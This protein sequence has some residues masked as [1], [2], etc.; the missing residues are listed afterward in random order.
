MRFS[1]YTTICE[2]R[3]A[4]MRFS[5]G[6]NNSGEDFDSS[7]GYI[8]NISLFVLVLLRDKVRKGVVDTSSFLFSA[9]SVHDVEHEHFPHSE[10]KLQKHGEFANDGLVNESSSSQR[11]WCGIHFVISEKVILIKPM[12]LV[13]L[14]SLWSLMSIGS[15]LVQRLQACSV[16]MFYLKQQ[17]RAMETVVKQNNLDIEALMSSRLPSNAGMQVGDSS[18]SQLAGSSQRAGITRDSKAALSGTEIVKPDAFSS[19]RPPSGHG[20]YQGSAANIN[21]DKYGLPAHRL[22]CMGRLRC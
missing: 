8:K 7:T 6:F 13:H 11:V 12:N 16:N 14:V 10:F 18:S 22:V 1:G 20:I 9:G 15:C 21:A 3:A 5:L 4:A 17:M 2:A 19:S